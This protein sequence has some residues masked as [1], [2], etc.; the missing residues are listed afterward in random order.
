[1]APGPNAQGRRAPARGWDEPCP[2]A[3]RRGSAQRAAGSGRCDG[4]GAS[5]MTCADRERDAHR[6]DARSRRPRP[7]TRHVTRTRRGGRV[8]PVGRCLRLSWVAHGAPGF[9]AGAGCL[10]GSFQG[11]AAQR[12]GEC[13]PESNRQVELR[14]IGSPLSG[15]RGS[16]ERTRQPPM[17]ETWTARA[18]ACLAAVDVAARRRDQ[19]R[20][21]AWRRD[22]DAARKS[23]RHGSG[24]RDSTGQARW[25]D[26]AGCRRRGEGTATRG[27]RSARP[28]QRSGWAND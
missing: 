23:A 7:R 4:A 5:A 21:G 16:P 19:R 26:R 1:M 28:R 18:G 10:A 6:D 12:S 13:D 3:T 9:A 20:T 25:C 8:S 24:A 17:G 11:R 27:G 14:T 15:G 22:R 2:P